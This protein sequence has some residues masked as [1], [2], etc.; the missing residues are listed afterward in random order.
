M[1]SIWRKNVDCKLILSHCV[2]LSYISKYVAKVEV[3]LE[4]YWK[5]LARLLESAFLEAHVVT[6][7]KKFLTKI[8]VDRDIGA[9]EIC[10]MLHK[11]SLTHY[12]HSFVALNVNQ[13]IFRHVLQNLDSP[14]STTTF[15]IA[16]YMEIST[17]MEAFALVESA[18]SW[19]FS[20]RRKHF[21]WKKMYPQL[22]IHV[23]PSYTFI[24]SP[25]DD[26]YAN[27]LW[28]ELLIYL[29]FINSQKTLVC[30]IKKLFQSGNK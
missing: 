1:I 7:V 19:S 18:C 29:P 5:M 22:V 11:I 24:P 16:T 14:L 20:S 23:F 12:N 9:Q 30:L 8:V 26:C 3:K 6:I 10:H 17:S 27:L 4:S 15:N 13:T 2:V 28:S 25:T 21:Q